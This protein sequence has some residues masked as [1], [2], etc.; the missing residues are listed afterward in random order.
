[1]SFWWN[2]QQ[3]SALFSYSWV[4]EYHN[5]AWTRKRCDWVLG[6]A[7]LQH[8]TQQWQRL[9]PGHITVHPTFLSNWQLYR[10]N[11][12]HYSFANTYLLLLYFSWLYTMLK[13][14]SSAGAGAFILG[15]TGFLLFYSS[16]FPKLYE[17]IGTNSTFLKDYDNES[18]NKTTVIVKQ[19]ADT[20][21]IL[22]SSRICGRC[23]SQKEWMVQ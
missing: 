23:I 9:L 7:H 17:V 16:S 21:D 4:T 11:K 14:V 8:K 12:L 2:L 20:E 5:S 22:C 6:G 15:I 1:M 19:D 13:R 18:F 3:R 10:P